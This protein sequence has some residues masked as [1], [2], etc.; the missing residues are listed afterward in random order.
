MI[1]NGVTLVRDTGM[2]TDFVL[3]V[4]NR[5]NCG[6]L[7]G[8]EMVA[9]GAILDGTPPIIP[10]I[11]V[12][13]RTPDEARAAVRQQAA[14]GVDMI[15]VYSRLSRD[16]FFAILDEAKVLGLKVVGHVPDTVSIE[17]AAAAGLACSEHFFGFEQVIGSSSAGRCA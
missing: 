6:D 8:P 12:G 17:V 7:L 1:A 10:S 14:A 16:A 5:L 11:S 3:E 4:R 2:P 13:V 15:K 9:T